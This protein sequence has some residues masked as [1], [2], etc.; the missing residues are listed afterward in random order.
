MSVSSSNKRNTAMDKE[1][2]TLTDLIVKA[3][4]ALRFD[5]IQHPSNFAIQEYIKRVFG[6]D[7]SYEDIVNRTSVG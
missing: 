5:G 2:Y 1:T 7:V 4:Q 3:I 6:I